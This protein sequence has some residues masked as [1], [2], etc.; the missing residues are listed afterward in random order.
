M[1][2]ETAKRDIGTIQRSDFFQRHLKASSWLYSRAKLLRAVQFLL[3]VLIPV[4]LAILSTVFSDPA[5]S[6]AGLKGWAAFYG[7]AISL[8]DIAVLEGAQF[9]FRKRAARVQESF[10]C[11]LLGL[12]WSIFKV[13][14]TPCPEDI[15]YW[16]CAFK[17]EL[18]E[19]QKNWYPGA[20]GELPLYLGRIVCQRSNIWWDK[21]LRHRFIQFVIGLTVSF[22]IIATIVGFVKEMTLPVFILSIMAPISPA[23]IWLIKEAKRQQES[24]ENLNRLMTHAARLWQNALG[25]TVSYSE[26]KAKSREL[27]DEIFLHRSS[28]QPV[29]NWFN[30]LFSSSFDVSM[31]KGAEV[32]VAEAK[33]RSNT[34]G[35]AED[36]P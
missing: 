13:G 32:L 11:N 30:R 16:A 4:L 20:V 33:T 6:N 8:M 7:I 3:T 23:L 14:D 24:S 1:L 15:D 5:E 17:I 26:M 34:S 2:E 27:Q 29:P 9:S 19:N 21:T 28:N 22:V 35:T 31:N 12:P 36:Q 10:D 18:T 25:E